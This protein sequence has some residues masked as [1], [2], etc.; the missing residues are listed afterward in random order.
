MGSRLTTATIPL[1]TG[2]GEQAMRF[3]DVFS[4]IGP[5]MVGPSSSHT[6]GAA[7]LGRVARRLHGAQP[8]SAELTLYG[9]FAATYKGHGTDLALIGG[10]L[11]FDTDDARIREARELAEQAQMEVRFRTAMLPAGHPN[12]VTIRVQS[13][14][15][16]EDTVTGA[17]IG[18]GN[19]E[20][21][22][23]NGFDVRFTAD[24]P[25]LLVFHRDQ[26]GM[27]ADIS[28]LL[29]AE[30]INIGHMNVNRK[31]RSGDA[32]TVVEMDEPAHPAVLE[33]LARLA[34]VS[35]ISVVNIRNG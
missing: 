6:A 25:T 14:D 21:S 28:R 17:S 33:Q 1:G 23:V 22:G 3:K 12:T 11:D 34:E 24:Y 30:G 5:S 31:S 32:L 8:E 9:S 19:I 10:L 29:S 15:G 20:I 4:I 18:G 27:V 2:K 13:A 16:R 7:R 35:R 26:R